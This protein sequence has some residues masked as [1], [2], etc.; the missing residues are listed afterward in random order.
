[1]AIKQSPPE[2]Q[3]QV[4]NEL[5]N[6]TLNPTDIEKRCIELCKS[7]SDPKA[8]KGNAKGDLPDPLADF[9]PPLM[10]KQNYSGSNTSWTASYENQKLPNGITMPG[11][12]FSV[13]VPGMTPKTELKRWFQSM[14][15]GI[16]DTS[17]EENKAEAIM[18]RWGPANEQEMSQMIEDGKDTRLPRT[19]QE[20]SELEALANLGPEALYSWIYGPN[21]F[22][23]Q[24][25]KGMTWKDMDVTDPIDGCRKM[26]ESLKAV[27]SINVSD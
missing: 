24:K 6:G 18:K 4:S 23:T 20:Q 13:V 14:V 10:M 2:V 5:K 1:M 17:G 9:W 21:S 8:H 27:E 7:V 25:V 3:L 11:W 19:P 22:Y 26:V 12:R 15:D 16:G